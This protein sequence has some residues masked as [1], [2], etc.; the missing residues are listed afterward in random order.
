VPI[1]SLE[2]DQLAVL[3]NAQRLMLSLKKN[4]PWEGEIKYYKAKNKNLQDHIEEAKKH[5]ATLE[6]HHVSLLS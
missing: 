5:I 2:K 1:Y 3:I 4:N 6:Q